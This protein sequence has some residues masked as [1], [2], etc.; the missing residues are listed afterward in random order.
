MKMLKP[1]WWPV[2]P[3]PED[4]FPMAREKYAVI[5]PDPD[6]RTALSGMLGRIF[7]EMASETCW[8]AMEKWPIAEVKGLTAELKEAEAKER[9]K[10]DK[11]WVPKELP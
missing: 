11:Y 10:R 6:I 1:D 7:W 2:N 8:E 3:Y 4:I 5:V 9:D